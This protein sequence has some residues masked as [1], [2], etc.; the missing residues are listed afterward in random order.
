MN[1][2]GEVDGCVVVSEV[3][4]AVV[5]VIVALVSRNNVKIDCNF[6]NEK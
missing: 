4:V 1:Y 6:E 2:L 3:D 5:L